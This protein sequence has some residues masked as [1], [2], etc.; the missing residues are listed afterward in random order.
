LSRPISTE[1]DQKR[2]TADEER[3]L[4][5]VVA[6]DLLSSMA[7]T[8]ALTSAGRLLSAG[9]HPEHERADAVL[10]QVEVEAARVVDRLARLVRGM[11]VPTRRRTRHATGMEL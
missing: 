6:H 10:R 4:V 1:V 11:A 7:A 9:R 8:C 3:P 5:V 2:W